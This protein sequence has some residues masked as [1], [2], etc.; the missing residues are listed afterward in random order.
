MVLAGV[1]LKLGGY[2]FFRFSSFLNIP[3]IKRGYLTRMGV[4]GGLVRCFLCMRQ[5]DLKAFVAYSSICHM[6]F[7]LGGL[8]SFSH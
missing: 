8:Y 6:G 2:G 4:V 5:F 7:G 1:L 3:L